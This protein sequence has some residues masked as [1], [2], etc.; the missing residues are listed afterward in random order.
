MK[1]RLA[2][3][4]DCPHAEFVEHLQ[5]TE[6]FRFITWPILTF[7]PT[8]GNWPVQWQI[9]HDRFDLRFF[10]LI[11]MGNQEINISNP[12]HGVVAHGSVVLRDDGQGTLMR[13]WDHW[14]FTKP[15][16]ENQTHYVDEVE[17]IARYLP[18]F[19]TALFA[20]F[21]FAFYAHRQRR[22]KKYLLI[23]RKTS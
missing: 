23:K 12:S 6:S 5:R 15:F 13:R 9:G 7:Q 18:I 17:V 16:G 4:F 10:G 11:P 3:V 22:W 19:M 8:I 1:I 2:A 14:I 21:A 20:V